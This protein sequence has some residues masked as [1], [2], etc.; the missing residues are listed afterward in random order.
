MLAKM[1]PILQVSTRPSDQANVADPESATNNP[2]LGLSIVE[3]KPG[4]QT[5]PLNFLAARKWLITSIVSA[6]ILAVTLTSSA[7]SAS[8]LQVMAEFDASPDVFALGVSLYVLGFAV[9][10]PL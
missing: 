4:D 5:D 6:S 9:G 3:F 7:Y 1:E 8:A 10:P 2:V